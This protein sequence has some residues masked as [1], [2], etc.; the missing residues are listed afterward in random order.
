MARLKKGVLVLGH[1]RE[2][3]TRYRYLLVAWLNRALSGTAADREAA[4]RIGALI[5]SMNG[6]SFDAQRAGISAWS[7]KTPDSI[8]EAWQMTSIPSGP[9]PPRSPANKRPSISS[10]LT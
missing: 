8:T 2:R 7:S 6:S 4:G 1:S 5:K 3:N 10:T 9:G